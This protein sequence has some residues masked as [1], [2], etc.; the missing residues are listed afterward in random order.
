MD[1][2]TLKLLLKNLDTVQQDLKSIDNRGR[3]IEKAVI[4]LETSTRLKFAGIT[5]VASLLA[6]LG[7]WVLNEMLKVGSNQ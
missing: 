7:T 5:T 2:N 1:E 4:R 6:T 3:E